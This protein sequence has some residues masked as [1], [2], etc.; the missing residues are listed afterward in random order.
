MLI[1]IKMIQQGLILCERVYNTLKC[2]SFAL[3]IKQA[4]SYYLLPILHQGLKASRAIKDGRKYI[5][6]FPSSSRMEIK[7]RQ[8]C[9]RNYQSQGLRP[10][11]LLSSHAGPSILNRALK[12]A[13]NKEQQAVAILGRGARWS[14]TNT[15]SCRVLGFQETN[16][17]RQAPAFSL[18][19]YEIPV[20]STILWGYI[21]STVR[22]EPL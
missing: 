17:L 12:Q 13:R 16:S 8:S 22:K 21:L 2:F 15:A 3:K 20:E 5:N 4:S 19:P 1:G 9:Y 10:G 7:R 6:L 18:F 11:S 14:S